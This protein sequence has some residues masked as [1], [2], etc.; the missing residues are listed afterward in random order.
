MCAE[1]FFLHQLPGNS[2][3]TI[4]LGCAHDLHLRGRRGAL[5][6][7]NVNIDPAGSAYKHATLRGA[8][9]CKLA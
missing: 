8:A 5:G 1:A 9:A 2:H 4:S 7:C 6:F 3:H